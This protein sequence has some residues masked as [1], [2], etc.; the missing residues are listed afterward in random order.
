MAL[1]PVAAVMARTD[2][3]HCSIPCDLH[4]VP[5]LSLPEPPDTAG[6]ADKMVQAS[7]NRST[8]HLPAW[9]LCLPGSEEVVGAIL[10]AALA[11]Y[12]CYLSQGFG[13][14]VTGKGESYGQGH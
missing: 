6:K 14:R 2:G 5:V 10:Q 4:G 3:V 1:F 8:N 12:C 11:R 7:V 13:S 9:F